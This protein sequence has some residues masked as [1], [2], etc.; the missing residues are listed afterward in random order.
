MYTL[1]ILWLSFGISH[2][3]LAATNVRAFFEKLTP[4]NPN[5]FRL[6]YNGISLF[7]LY[8]IVEKTIKLNEFMPILNN[9]FL[10]KIIGGALILS[11]M[12]V[13]FGVAKQ[14]N[15]GAFL[16]FK[17]EE[18]REGLMTD[19]WYQIVRHP[20]YFGLILLFLGVFLVFPTWGV[21]ISL[22]FSKLYILIG[23]EFE[24]KK[25]RR[26]F[27]QDYVDFSNGKKKFIPFIY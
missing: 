9:Y 26:V 21:F 15:L 5:Y 14:M 27:G 12:Y 19:G 13:L 7:L 24:E 18:N 25:L 23:I 2:S 17:K 3:L 8:L 20:L 10:I 11:S 22:V 6:I 4:N 16:G 1:I